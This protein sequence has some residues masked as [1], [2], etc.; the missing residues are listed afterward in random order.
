MAQG[1]INLSLFGSKVA[2]GTPNRVFAKL[3]FKTI[4]IKHAKIR[5][6]LRR[7]E[8]AKLERE[9]ERLQ[10]RANNGNSVDIQQYLLKKEELKQ[11][12]LKLLESVKIRAKAQFLEEGEKSTRYF[13]SLEKARKAGKTISVLTKENLDTVSQRQDWIAETY[14]FYKDLFSAEKCDESARD[15][16]FRRG[17]CVV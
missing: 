11:L 7:H 5:G 15:R 2:R 1:P 4:A 3:Y 6:K 12:D 17:A 16:L 10:V 9:L 14:G 13:D 8:R